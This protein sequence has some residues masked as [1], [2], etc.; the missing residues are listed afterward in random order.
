MGAGVVSVQCSLWLNLFP[1]L[2]IPH[3]ACHFLRH[4]DFPKPG[5]CKCRGGQH[6][7]RQH[8]GV[9]GGEGNV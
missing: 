1:Q 5:G 7:F 3:V 6:S 4:R 2:E 9:C 8:R